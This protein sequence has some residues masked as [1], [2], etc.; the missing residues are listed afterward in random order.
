MPYDTIDTATAPQIAGAFGLPL[1]SEG[2]T[3]AALRS[4]LQLRLKSRA[5]VTPEQLDE[6]INEAYL[7]VCA[8]LPLAEL[9]GQL[10]FTTVSGQS[11]YR[12]PVG[13]YTIVT[14]RTVDDGLPNGGLRLQKTDEDQ[15][16]DFVVTQDYPDKFFRYGRYLV[17][18]PVPNGSYTIAV[19]FKVRPQKM[20]LD[21]DSPIFGEELHTALAYRANA[22]AIAAL[23]G[24]DAAAKE[25]AMYLAEVRPKI[26]PTA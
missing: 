9:D 1:T 13:V 24:P 3:L 7:S 6:W 25:L 21:T 16:R 12:L 18:W 11:S 23:D 4:R 26:D 15:Y 19:S 10:R 14:A 22:V 5:D 8:E 2:K 17:L 20:I